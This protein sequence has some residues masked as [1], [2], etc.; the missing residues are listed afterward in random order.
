MD[1]EMM[2]KNISVRTLRDSQKNVVTLALIMVGV[3]LL[4]L[5]LGGLLYL[6][7]P[8]VGVTAAGDRIFPAIVLGH[9][10]PAIQVIFIVAL[11][12]ALF[13]S[14]DGALTALTSSFCIDILGLKRRGDLREAQVKRI[15]RRVHLA[16][17]FLFLALV[18]AFHWA[19]S[20][21]MIGVILQIAAYTYGPLLGLFAFGILTRRTVRDP[22]VPFIALTAP[23]LC[24]FLDAHQAQL[25]GEYQLG[26]ELLVVNGLITFAGLWLASKPA[27]ESLPLHVA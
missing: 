19:D 8:A 6:Y 7:A 1:Q 4:F 27:G 17:A 16:F 12:S 18:L 9:L 5:Y 26:L 20:P 23:V 3:V 2:Q 21:S 15:R 11:I 10:A 13:P 24:Y 14:A 22:L 25:F